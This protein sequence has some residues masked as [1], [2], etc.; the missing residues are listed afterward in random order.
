MN[1]YTLYNVSDPVNPQD[2]ATK[3]YADKMVNNVGK[4]VDEKNA[5]IKSEVDDF[6]KLLEYVKKSTD[7]RHDKKTYIIAV[8]SNYCSLLRKGE[9]QFVF[10]GNITQPSGRVKR[11]KVKISHVEGIENLSKISIPYWYMYDFTK[12]EPI[13][14]FTLIKEKEKKKKKKKKKTS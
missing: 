13:F 2:V 1:G 8:H 7:E 5:Y 6:T 14:T 10:G 12:P 4:Y 11:I 9:Y 3:D